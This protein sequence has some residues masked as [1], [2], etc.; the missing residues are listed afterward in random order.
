MRSE[1]NLMEHIDFNILFRWFVGL[2]IDAPVWDHSTFTKNRE[3]FLESEVAHHFFEKVV[4]HARQKGLLS[5][6]HFT[7]DGT[8]LEAWASMK[9][10]QPKTPSDTDSD[11][12]SAGKNPDV[13]FHG[14][15]RTN[16]T[17]ASR[18]DPDAR[19]YKKSA[20]SA[21]KLCYM[22]HVLME[23]RNGLVVKNTLTHASGTAEREAALSMMGELGTTRHRT[24]GGDKGY[25]ADDFVQ[26]LRD[27]NITPHIA[28]KK[29]SIGIDRR[30]TR[31]EG[32]MTSQRIRKRVEE[33]FG[34][35]KTVGMIRKVKLRGV[36]LVDG[37]FAF[38]MAVY[39]LI[40]IGNLEVQT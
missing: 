20:G 11:A 22:G 23:N 12:G 32:F 10:F 15:K 9:S 31:H 38:N 40:R 39:N 17:H 24:L 6:D 36:K 2:G 18:T 35:A 13:D 4:E 5:D 34:W 33:I 29:N 26:A 14:E 28:P 19:L 25:D 21:S 8:L 30:T 7:V 16:A 27:I 37:L 1:R 3:R